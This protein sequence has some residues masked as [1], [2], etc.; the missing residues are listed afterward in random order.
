MKENI[1]SKDFAIETT[2]WVIIF[3]TRLSLKPEVVTVDE[4]VSVKECR[5]AAINVWN[6]L[7]TRIEESGL[8]YK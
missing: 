4:P 3:N 2:D 5:E 7:I 8:N 1:M 6:T